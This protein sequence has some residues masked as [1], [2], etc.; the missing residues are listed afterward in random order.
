MCAGLQKSG[1]E[2]GRAVLFDDFV[3]MDHD[4]IVDDLEVAAY[5]SWML[6]LDI[7]IGTEQFSWAVVH[8]AGRSSVRLRRSLRLGNSIPERL[9]RRGGKRIL[10][11]FPFFFL[12]EGYD[13]PHEYIDYN[14]S[15]SRSSYYLYLS[16]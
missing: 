4:D 10:L 1:T 2:A 6:R 15:D 9:S 16:I 5:L 12:L 14:E 13:S 8:S 7:V 3:G 11:V